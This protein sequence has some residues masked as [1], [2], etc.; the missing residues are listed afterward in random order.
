MKKNQR[1]K[2]HID[3]DTIVGLSTLIG[4]ILFAI[5]MGIEIIPI[6]YSI[7]ITIL[8][9]FEGLLLGAMIWLFVG[10]LIAAF[11]CDEPE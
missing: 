11:V 1:K 4:A 5:L 9:L 6:S 10:C 7:L 2:N 8:M 3:E